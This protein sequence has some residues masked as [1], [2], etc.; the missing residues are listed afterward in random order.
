MAAK[1]FVI[2]TFELRK[3]GER[4][5]GECKELGTATFAHTLDQVHE[6]LAE[7]VELHLN[8]LEKVGERDRFFKAHRIKFYTDETPP[9]RVSRRIPVN[10]A[11]FI[12]SHTVPIVFS[13]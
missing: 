11:T 10:E 6:E 5:T 12:H 3:E 13:T 9:R 4:W 7:L 1:G 2:L 8:S